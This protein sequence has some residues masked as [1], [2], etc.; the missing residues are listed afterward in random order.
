MFNAVLAWFAVEICFGH[1]LKVMLCYEFYGMPG[2][3]WLAIY[4]CFSLLLGVHHPAI[5]L[6]FSAAS[7]LWDTAYCYRWVWCLSVTQL[8]SAVHAVCAVSFVVAFVKSLWPFVCCYVGSAYF[9]HVQNDMCQL[10]PWLA[11]IGL[12][13]AISWYVCPHHFVPCISSAD[14]LADWIELTVIIDLYY[15]SS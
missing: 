9:N 10:G 13:S 7:I 14:A 15:E 2:V 12:V 8:N 6:H 5:V 1:E 3:Y 4:P 11:L